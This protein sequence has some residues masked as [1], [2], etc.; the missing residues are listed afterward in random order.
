MARIPEGFLQRPQ[1]AATAAA[2]MPVWDG[3]GAVD[4]P[5]RHLAN[6]SRSRV[7]GSEVA[8]L[9]GDQVLEQISHGASEPL[10]YRNQLVIINAFC[11]PRRLF[12]HDN[13]RLQL[14]G[15]S[16]TGD[17]RDWSR[18]SFCEAYQRR[19]RKYPRPQ[20]SLSIAPRRWVVDGIPQL[21]CFIFCTRATETK[22]WGKT[23]PYLRPAVAVRPRWLYLNLF[24]SLSSGSSREHCADRIKWIRRSCLLEDVLSLT[25][26]RFPFDKV[27]CANARAHVPSP[28]PTPS[29]SSLTVL[30]HTSNRLLYRA[31]S[32]PLE[33][34]I[35]CIVIALVNGCALSEFQV[36]LANAAA[37]G[38]HAL[39]RGAR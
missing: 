4:R 15:V 22:P 27:T 28:Q 18:G 3:C 24:A 36:S 1:G 8:V 32:I 23:W 9:G 35:P 34:R 12:L 38:L 17:P 30:R 16:S 13:V 14:R 20:F 11:R 39:R 37:C 31:S 25:G 2:L 5:V 6:R 10:F 29:G 21:P 7:A 33:Y 26:L 19:L